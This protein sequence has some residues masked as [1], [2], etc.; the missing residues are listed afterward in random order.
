MNSIL[1]FYSCNPALKTR[2]RYKNDNE[3]IMIMMIMIMMIMMIKSF[4]NKGDVT[5]TVGRERVTNS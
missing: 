2:F 3:I 5:L 4:E 1:K